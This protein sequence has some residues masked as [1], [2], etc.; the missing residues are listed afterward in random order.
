MGDGLVCAK[1]GEAIRKI[2]TQNNWKYKRIETP[3]RKGK[4]VKQNKEKNLSSWV[5]QR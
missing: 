3:P 2:Q 4:N 1:A 5:F